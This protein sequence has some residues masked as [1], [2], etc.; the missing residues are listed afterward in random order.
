MSNV[1]R[2]LFRYISA[3]DLDLPP[4]LFDRLV[5]WRLRVVAPSSLTLEVCTWSSATTEMISVIRTYVKFYLLT[6]SRFVSHGRV[7]RSGP[8]EAFEHVGTPIPRPGNV[9][10]EIKHSTRYLDRLGRSISAILQAL[11]RGVCSY[12][13]DGDRASR[14]LLRCF[15]LKASHF[16]K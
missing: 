14:Q 4:T 7:C 11:N 15:A 8:K 2:P 16:E 12:L 3:A 1:P 9:R 5:F 13:Y 6:I 10:R